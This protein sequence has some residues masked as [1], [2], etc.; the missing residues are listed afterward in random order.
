MPDDELAGRYC[1]LDMVNTETGEIYV[2]AGD[3]LTADNIQL[4]RE[5][6][7]TEIVTLNV[8]HI[9]IGGYIRNTMAVDKNHSREQALVSS[10]ARRPQPPQGCR[11]AYLRRRLG[12]P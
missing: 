10:R 3:E 8:D 7:F 12:S 11:S 2:E 6:K 5:A 9:N 1:A 4:L